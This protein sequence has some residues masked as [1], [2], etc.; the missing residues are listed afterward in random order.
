MAMLQAEMV[1][2][3]VAAVAAG[4]MVLRLDVAATARL[5][6]NPDGVLASAGML[7]SLLKVESQG[8]WVIG[9]LRAIEQQDGAAV[10]IID[11]VGEAEAD[12]DGRITRFRRGVGTY[13]RAG[14]RA[15]PMDGA[16]TAR[17]FS[18][19]ERPHIQVGIVYPTGQV[20]AAVFFDTFLSK[21]FAIVGSTG[22]G[23][24]TATALFLHRIIEQAPQGH[25]VVIDPH[26]EYAR[27]FAD[28]GMI[29]NVD[30]LELPYWLLN[31]EEHCEV[32]LTSEGAVREMDRD[33]LAR[34]LQLARMKS[35][36]AQGLS[37]VTTD[38]PIPYLLSALMDTLASEMGK[39]SEGQNAPNY[40]RIRGKLEQIMRDPRHKFMFDRRY[41]NDNMAEFMSRIL[42]LP[43]AGKPISVIDLSGVPSA[44]V[45]AVVS[46]LS[47]I[48]FDFAVWSRGEQ[49]RPVVL[50]CEEA[51]RYIPS[52]SISKHSTVRDVLERIAKEGRKYGVS[53]GLVTQ[54]PSDL[55]E[56]ALSQCGT[57]V[58]LR[59]NNDRDQAFVKNALPEG[60]RSL[61]DA[62][63]ALRNRECII[64][65]EGVAAPIRVRLD[66]LEPHKRPAS[67]D[68]VFSELWVET[69]DDDEMLDR[70]IARWRAN[71]R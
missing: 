67:D 1:I 26:G 45:S 53:L 58:S 8:L 7:G 13:P 47:R 43:V 41:S 55:A 46:V 51:H 36:Y 39:I 69:G 14:D 28:T 60:G 18:G 5:K 21:N 61:L 66:D 68:R 17:V 42:R 24:S 48:V 71:T 6:S 62:I 31:F 16:E 9:T 54:R 34:C 59:L 2:G 32:L 65:G 19:D 15:W 57:I 38:T 40:L 12:P 23:K 4:Q 20:R 30:N 52:R 27:A 37:S 44:V 29:F 64:S 35:V 25:V 3:A 63:P 49:R 10:G 56:G 22:T 50:V 11:F 33:I 70:V